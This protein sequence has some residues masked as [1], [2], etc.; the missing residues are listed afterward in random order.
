MMPEGHRNMKKKYAV[1]TSG[2]VASYVSS[3]QEDGKL[4]R[5]SL[6]AGYRTLN[7]HLDKTNSTIYFHREIARVFCKKKTVRHKYVIHLNHKKADNEAKN[8]RWVTREEMTAHQQKSPQK[9]AYKK[10]QANRTTGLK[11]TAAQVRSIK[12]L[13][14]NPKR[15][16]SYRQIAWKYNVSEMTL[17]RIKSGEN[18]RRIK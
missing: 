14:R 13:M 15:K 1:S 4:L 5:G 9:L 2:R 7:L 16:M 12:D 6:T 8:L 3:L 17:Y 10:R 18:W 11:L